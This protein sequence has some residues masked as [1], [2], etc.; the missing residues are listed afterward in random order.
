M[1]R[2]GDVSVVL[3]PVSAI[4]MSVIIFSFILSCYLTVNCS[5]AECCT[6]FSVVIRPWRWTWCIL[7]KQRVIHRL[8]DAISHLMIIFKDISNWLHAHWQNIVDLMVVTHRYGRCS[9]RIM[10]SE[11]Q[12]RCCCQVALVCLTVV[13]SLVSRPHVANCDTYN[14][15]SAGMR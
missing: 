2:R 11:L 7:P 9:Q 1:Q 6:L 4:I 10:C 8:Y 3:E 5:F 15:V 14:T 13:V 12:Y